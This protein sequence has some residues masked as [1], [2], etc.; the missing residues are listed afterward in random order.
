VEV[1]EEAVDDE[2]CPGDVGGIGG[3]EVAGDAGKGADVDAGAAAGVLDQRGAGLEDAESA[4]DVDLEDLVRRRPVAGRPADPSAEI[5][6]SKGGIGP[7][8]GE[9]V[10]S[11]FQTCWGYVHEPQEF[12]R[13]A[14][15]LGAS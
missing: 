9:G 15:Q 13:A 11:A 6:V 8:W 1:L 5:L 7:S 12:I 14:D 4:G 10:S 3:G 2:A